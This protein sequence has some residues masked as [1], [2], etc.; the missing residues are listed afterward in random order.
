MVNGKETVA[1]PL[2]EQSVELTII[3]SIASCYYANTFS[4]HVLLYL[5]QG[6]KPKLLLLMVA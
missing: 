2:S 4:Y 5:T 1:P 3:S 6:Y